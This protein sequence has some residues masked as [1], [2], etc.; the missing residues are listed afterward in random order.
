MTFSKTHLIAGTLALVLV[1]GFT[2]PV[3]AGGPPSC[4]FLVP[5]SVGGTGVCAFD[6]TVLSINETL[7]S[8]NAR[9]Y[10]EISGLEVGTD[11]QVIK[12]IKNESSEPINRYFHEI[13]DGNPGSIN[14]VVDLWD[15]SLEAT[16]SESDNF[17]GLSFAMGPSNPTIDRNS[18]TWPTPGDD[19]F[20]T[21]DFLQ[22]EGANLLPGNND[23]TAFGLRNLNP[24]QPPFLLAQ[25]PALG[26]IPITTVAG[27]L[28]SINS[29]TLV[30]GGLASSAV[31]IVPTIAGIAGAGVY[32]VKLRA[33]RD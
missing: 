9:L 21:R 13:L 23:T 18:T 26:I 30:I 32:I 17:D 29:S 8:S 33:N 28:L 11:Y 25:A 19:E 1:A 4:S 6:G 14:T 16:N 22:F 12:I 7:T 2:S 3:F 27:E 10:F 5:P 15:E 20:N 24:N 31:W